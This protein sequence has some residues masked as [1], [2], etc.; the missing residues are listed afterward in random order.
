MAQATEFEIYCQCCGDKHFDEK[1]LV[2]VCVHCL[3]AKFIPRDFW[4]RIAFY[5]AFVGTNP[6]GWWDKIAC[7][8]GVRIREAVKQKMER[9][10]LARRLFLEKNGLLDEI[11]PKGI[12]PKTGIA[13]L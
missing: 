3:Q 5:N 2:K 6:R 13:E 4:G 8:M 9:D 10:A 11:E 7:D 1:D 12:D